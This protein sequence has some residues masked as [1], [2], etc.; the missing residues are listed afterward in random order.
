MFI[1][2]SKRRHLILARH[3]LVVLGAFLS[4]GC[5]STLHRQPARQPYSRGQSSERYSATQVTSLNSENELRSDN[6]PFPAGDPAV[7]TLV[8]GDEASTFI[9]NDTDAAK[10]FRGLSGKL[11]RN[12]MGAVV[13][14]DLSYSDVSDEALASIDI[15]ADIVELDLTGTRVHDESLVV[16]CSSFQNCSLS[17]SRGLQLLM[18]ESPR[19]RKFRPWFCW[20]PRTLMRL[21]KDFM[22]LLNGPIFDIYP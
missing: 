22:T 12:D 1:Y 18:L 3:I 4:F 5:E 17:N 21:T 11:R 10:M 7:R 14:A 20:M 19:S 13:E 2:D 16:L 9:P 8:A 6:S 15:F